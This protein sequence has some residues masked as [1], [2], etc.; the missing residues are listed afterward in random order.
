MSS[1]LQPTAY[2]KNVLR[3]LAVS[4]VGTPGGVPTPPGHP[5]TMASYHS[6]H[7]RAVGTAPLSISGRFAVQFPLN[8]YTMSSMTTPTASW[9]CSRCPEHTKQRAATY[10][11][12]RGSA[13]RRG[14]DGKW[15][16]VRARFLQLHPQC[17]GLCCGAVATEVDHI[18]ALKHGGT[19]AFHNLRGYCK[20]HHSSKTARVDGRWGR[21]GQSLL[22][23]RF[24]RA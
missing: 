1:P 21:R 19:H 13:T 22:P 6:I 23:C 5:A 11:R 3:G 17:S 7:R 9:H 12:A 20:R 4:D 18:T 16:L 2:R 8:Q 24:V 10:D 15:W 14:Y